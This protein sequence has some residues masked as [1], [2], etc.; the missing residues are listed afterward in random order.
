MNSRLDRARWRRG[1]RRLSGSAASLAVLTLASAVPMAQ[2]SAGSPAEAVFGRPTTSSPIAL[3][4]DDRLV[5]SV[6]PKDDTVSVIRTDTNQVVRTIRVGDEPQSVALDPNNQFAFVANAAGSSVSV[7]RI[8]NPHQ[9]GFNA[10]VERTLVTGAEPW[11]IVI[12]PD[13]KRVFVANSAQDTITVINAQTRTVIGHVD[14]RDS[15]CNAPDRRRHFQPRGLAVTQANDLLYVT[16]FLSFTRRGGRQGIDTGKEGAVCQLRIDT[17]ATQIGG[18][19]PLRRIALAPS[20]TGF[21]IDANGDGTPDP[22]RAFPNQLQSIVI[23]GD[24][25]FLPNI[26]ASASGPLQFQNDTEAFLNVLQGVTGGGA[27]VDRTALN[28]HLGARNPEPGRKTLFFA[29][30]W[31]IAFTNQS[32]NGNA[33]VVSAGSD[34]LVKLNVSAAGVIGFTVDMDTTRYIDLNDPNDP[35]TRGDNAGKNPRG[36]AITGDGRKAYVANFVSRNVSVVDLTR[37][38]V[39]DVV[40]TAALPPPGSQAER[41]LV[42]AEM[43]FSSRG[44][45]NR[46]GLTVPTDERLSQAGWQNCA[47][48]HFEGLTD[49]VVWQF[50]PG[51]RKSISLAGTFDPHNRNRQRILNY[52][53]LRD[54]VED[55]ELNIRNV[56]G[57]GGL[58]NPIGCS[59]PP[60]PQSNFDPNHGL[61]L[62]DVDRN[63]PPCVIND[64]LKPNRGRTQVTVTLPGSSVAVPALDALNLWVKFAVRTPN[65]PLTDA[66]IAGGVP[67]SQIQAGRALFASAGCTN[68]HN[69]G[70]WSKSVLDFGPPPAAGDIFCERNINNPALPG[71]QTD[72]IRGNPVA[73]QYLDRFLEDVGSYNL[74]VRGGN[75]PIGNNVG[76]VELA[77]QVLVAGRAQ[78]P[79]DG[80]G[81]DFNG[82]GRGVGF[83]VPSLLG[84]HA[85]PPYMHNGACETIACVVSD[86]EHRTGNG[87]F[88]DRLADPAQQRLVTRF[89]EAIDARA[90][91]FR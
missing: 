38:A 68:C 61:L 46:R 79:Q 35:D 48:C 80:L 75:N 78:P 87:R 1:A 49:G 58:A 63:Q 44:H 55:F 71:C 9:A 2:T 83:S 89:V 18:Y 91:P 66:Q 54:E 65:A 82:D 29:N 14:L 19:Q 53:A 33:Y 56:S 47:S 41:V 90:T 31:A 22:T 39:A 17:N 72:P 57:P 59:A 50:N 60:P 76:A 62:G 6:N 52:S 16:Q 45:F 74:G 40:R 86:R 12:S 77:T 30:P 26:A 11:N 24:R 73:F 7:I 27:P 20:N 5:W 21:A 34:L 8:T 85:V 81:I 43:F 37:D 25:A 3:S 10:V 67:R 32:G 23:R 51:P 13:G 84:I 69:G 88:P 4:L 64:F 15:L 28:L 42:G 70:L 36:I